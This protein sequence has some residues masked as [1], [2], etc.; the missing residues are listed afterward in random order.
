MRTVRCWSSMATKRCTDNSVPLFARSVPRNCHE[1]LVE[2]VVE[3]RLDIHHTA[4][5]SNHVEDVQ[6]GKMQNARR[7]PDLFNVVVAWTLRPWRQTATWPLQ[8]FVI[9]YGSR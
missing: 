8:K 1:R 4:Q 6:L 2:L 3:M 7:P 5:P 9:L